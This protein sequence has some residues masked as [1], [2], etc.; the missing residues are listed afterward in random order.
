MDEL[1]SD[2]K[3]NQHFFQKFAPCKKIQKP[4]LSID[5][6]H[7]LCL[8]GALKLEKATLLLTLAY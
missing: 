3:Q 2:L 4:Q 7:K 6:S 1:E 5:F 8:F